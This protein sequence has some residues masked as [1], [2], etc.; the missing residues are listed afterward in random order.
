SNDAAGL[1]AMYDFI[2]AV[3]LPGELD[4]FEQ[5]ASDHDVPGEKL[6][7]FVKEVVRSNAGR[8]TLPPSS[9]QGSASDGSPKSN[10][11]SK[12]IDLGDG[13]IVEIQ[14]G[15]TAAAATARALRMEVQ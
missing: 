5:L 15:E 14:P 6:F 4:R 2:T 12:V 8:P 1:A 11:E 7:D 3:V 13:R 9:S 10:S